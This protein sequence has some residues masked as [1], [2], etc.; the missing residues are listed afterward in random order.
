MCSHRFTSVSYRGAQSWIQRSRAEGQG[1]LPWPAGHD[2]FDAAQNV[3][4]FL[5]YKHCEL[6]CDV[7]PSSTPKAFSPS[8]H[9]PARTGTGDCPSPGAAPYWGLRFTWTYF[10]SLSV[11][12]W[13]TSLPTNTHVNCTTALGCLQTCWGCIQSYCLCH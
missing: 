6:V 11:T 12:P 13:R 7:A 1:H 8:V 5:G 2:S 10:S 3:A 9:P 4:G